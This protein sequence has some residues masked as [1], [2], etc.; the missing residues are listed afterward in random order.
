MNHDQQ[1]QKVEGLSNEVSNASAVKGA[2]LPPLTPLASKATSYID[3][4]SSVQKKFDLN[5]DIQNALE[6]FFGCDHVFLPQAELGIDDV[7]HLHDETIKDATVA[8]VGALHLRD[9][10]M[11]DLELYRLLYVYLTQRSLRRAINGLIESWGNFPT[12]R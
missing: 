12:Y 11:G 7:H 4:R 3:R 6:S 5:F 10:S 9:G 1:S 2:F 8:F